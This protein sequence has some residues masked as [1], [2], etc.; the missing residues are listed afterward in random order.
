MPCH[1][2][3]MSAADCQYSIA[4]GEIMYTTAKHA[5]DRFNA[6]ATS[7]LPFVF[8]AKHDPNDNVKEQFQNAWN[9]SVGGSRA[10]LLYLKEIVKLCSTYLDSAQWVLKHTSARSVADAVTAV[11]SMES[12]MSMETAQLLWPAL[13]KALGGKTW[14]GKEDVLLA[15]VKFVESANRYR[16]EKPAVAA[17]IVKVRLLLPIFG[18]EVWSLQHP[19]CQDLRHLMRPAVAFSIADVLPSQIAIRE[20]KRQNATYRQHSIKCVGQISRALTDTDMSDAVFGVVEPLL[21]DS[22]EIEPMEVDGEH[23]DQAADTV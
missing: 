16:S 8:V 13:E 15:F 14:E 9:E 22:T 1:L 4:S 18:A 23:T 19:L 11:A 20:A 3:V 12:N 2:C 10:V 7:A 21:H 6:I 17:A 5:N